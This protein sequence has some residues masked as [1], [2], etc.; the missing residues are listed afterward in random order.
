M[1]DSLADRIRE[2]KRKLQEATARVSTRASLRRF[3]SSG[4][5]GDS[6]CIYEVIAKSSHAGR[7]AARCIDRACE[8]FAMPAIVN[9]SRT[10]S[11]RTQ[12]SRGTTR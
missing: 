4:L 2:D 6:M 3:R 12:R 7:D 1:F 8:S 9:E 11:I 10:D 5:K